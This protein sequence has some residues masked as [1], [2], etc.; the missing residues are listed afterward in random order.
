MGFSISGPA[1][2]AILERLAHD[3]VSNDGFGFLTIRS[4]DVGSSQAVVGR[5][6]LTGE[7]GYEIVVPTVQHRTLWHELQEAGRDL[8]LRPIGDRAVDSLRLEKG[9]GI[10]SAEFR[11]DCTPGM[12]G[13]DRFVA[14]DEG[15]FIGAEAA[16]R[17]RETGPTWR[18]VLLEIDADDADARRD[19]GIWVGERR[20]GEITSGAYGHHVG[21]SLA[22]AYLERDVA[23]AAPEL[24]VFVVGDPRPARILPEPPYDPKGLRLRDL[25]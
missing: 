8:G 20:V 14:F 21:A 16:R 13:L 17:E 6:S 10:W 19:D 2:R 23:D 22:L 3:D 12:C 18:L 5:I 11:Q 15:G 25:A 4:M 1:S 7:L 24:T 9:Y